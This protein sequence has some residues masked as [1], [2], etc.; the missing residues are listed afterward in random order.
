MSRLTL[1]SGRAA[2]TTLGLSESN[3]SLLWFGIIILL[4]IWFSKK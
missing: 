4:V 1:K 3:F 2:F